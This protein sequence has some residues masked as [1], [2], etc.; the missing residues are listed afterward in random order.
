[1]AF[2]HLCRGFAN[3]LLVFNIV[4]LPSADLVLVGFK[5]HKKGDVIVLC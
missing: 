1:M 3:V 4:F 5:I 2:L